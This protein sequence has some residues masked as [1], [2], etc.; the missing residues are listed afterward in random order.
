M[1]GFERDDLWTCDNCIRVLVDD[2]EAK[3]CE[4][5][6]E[7]GKANADILIRANWAWGDDLEPFADEIKKKFI[8]YLESVKPEGWLK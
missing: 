6:Y 8:E 7:Y 1:C 5:C 2:P 3:L 4:E